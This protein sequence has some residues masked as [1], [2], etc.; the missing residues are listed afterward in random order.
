MLLG[1]AWGVGYDFVTSLYKLLRSKVLGFVFDFLLMVFCAL[2]FFSFL[3]GYNSGQIRVLLCVLS[4]IGFGV[5]LSTVHRVFARVFDKSLRF[6]RRR[7]KKFAKSLKI[8][9]KS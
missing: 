8:S 4:L 5:Y 6:L 7:T 9:K 3:I 1:M 2:S